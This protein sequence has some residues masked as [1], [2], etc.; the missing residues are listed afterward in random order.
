VFT[1]IIIFSLVYC[2]YILHKNLLLIYNYDIH[3]IY[4]VS[5]TINIFVQGPYVNAL[6]RDESYRFSAPKIN[7]NASSQR[8]NE[9]LKNFQIVVTI[10]PE[11]VTPY[12][13]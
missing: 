3:Y 8:K 12:Y 13:S 4:Y 6:E 9:Q 11:L 5:V 7:A 1:K 10:L 2:D